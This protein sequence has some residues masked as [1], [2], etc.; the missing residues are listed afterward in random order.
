MGDDTEQL[1]IKQGGKCAVFTPQPGH[2]Q[3]WVKVL[4]DQYVNKLNN[5]DHYTV[6]HVITTSG[7]DDATAQLER[8][9]IWDKTKTKNKT[10]CNNKLLTIT[11]FY[12]TGTI[13]AQGKQCQQWAE[14]KFIWLSD[15]AKHVREG[16]SFE[17]AI[18]KAE[19]W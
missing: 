2:L 8:F 14:D 15:A 4:T 7:E 10:K 17:A 12:S 18:E 19:G 3:A 16:M 11:V 1:C 9:Q 6:D 13:M 5:S